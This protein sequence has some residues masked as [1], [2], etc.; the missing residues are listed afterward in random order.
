LEALAVAGDLS[1]R[2]RRKLEVRTRI[3]DAA[4][5]LFE[6]QGFDGTKVS[7][8]CE[9]AD[10]AHKTFFNHF[11]S[12]QRMLQSLASHLIDQLVADIESACRQGR[13]TKERLRHF[14]THVASRAEEAGPMHR[15]L[16]TELV[17]TVH[18]SAPKSADAHKLH[19]A[20]GEIIR[21]GLA[22][23]EVTRRHDA[24]TLTRMI[25]GAYYVLMF[26]FVNL[27]QFPMR[28]QAMSVA[29][30]LEDA[31]TAETTEDLTAEAQRR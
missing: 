9:R 11:Q 24:E 19:V 12:K 8:I 13:S 14:F 7:D 6:E 1:R 27:D 10:V 5:A 29:R 17:H 21:V 3:L 28:K 2:D 26:D 4:A 15:E 25:L 20:F 31:L 30:F 18:V 16:L 22:A 23:G